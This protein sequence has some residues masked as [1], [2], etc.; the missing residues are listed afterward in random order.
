MTIYSVEFTK[1]DGDEGEGLTNPVLQVENVNNWKEW[2]VTGMSYAYSHAQDCKAG[3]APLRCHK[4]PWVCRW[5]E[6]GNTD[7]LSDRSKRWSCGVPKRGAKFPD[8]L[9]WEDGWSN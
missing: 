4:G 2:D 6:G 1:R 3:I 7:I 5:V 9:N 8:G